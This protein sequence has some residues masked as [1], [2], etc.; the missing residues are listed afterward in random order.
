MLWDANLLLYL[1]ASLKKKKSL[2]NIESIPLL[3]EYMNTE[4]L[5]NNG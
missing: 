2:K 1:T 4:Y 3:A 5:N